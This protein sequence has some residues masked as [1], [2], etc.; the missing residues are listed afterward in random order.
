MN[1]LFESNNEPK[2]VSF[3][4][5]HR[6]AIGISITSLLLVF[7]IVTIGLYFDWGSGPTQRHDCGSGDCVHGRVK[8][9]P[10]L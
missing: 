2:P 10:Q 3:F 6:R 7:A 5:R 4:R 9:P 8:L 1:T